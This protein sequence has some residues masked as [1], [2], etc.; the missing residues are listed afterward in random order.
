MFI[1]F[2]IYLESKVPKIP[3]CTTIRRKPFR[4]YDN[5]SHT[6]FGRCD[7]SPSTTNGRKKQS[8]TTFGRNCQDIVFRPNV[9][10]DGMSH[11]PNF[12]VY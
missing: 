11:R 4:R 9:V 1:Y 8:G 3:G 10:L 5:S 7:V 2:I 12:M 6:T